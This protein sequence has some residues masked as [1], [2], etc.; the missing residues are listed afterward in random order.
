MRI[1]KKKLVLIGGVVAVLTLL[2]FA[3]FYLGKYIKS[4]NLVANKDSL[5]LA[6]QVTLKTT[7]ANDASSKSS[8]IKVRYKPTNSKTWVEPDTKLGIVSGN[9][10]IQSFELTN[11]KTAT[12][13]EY[14]T[15]TIDSK[16]GISTWTPSS[17]FATAREKGK[18]A[19]SGAV[20]LA[21]AA[22]LENPGDISFDGKADN[23]DFYI[24]EFG[25][26]TKSNDL[27]TS[28]L[29]NHIYSVGGEM[30]AIMTAYKYVPASNN[31]FN[32]EEKYSGRAIVA[33][34]DIKFFVNL[35]VPVV[36]YTEDGG[37][38]VT[39]GGKTTSANQS[40]VALVDQNQAVLGSVSTN[41]P[42][43]NTNPV[44]IDGPA[45]IGINV[46]VDYSLKAKNNLLAGK[47]S[48]NLGEGLKAAGCQIEIPNTVDCVGCVTNNKIK[49]RLKCTSAG[50]G[51]LLISW[52]TGGNNGRDSI[53]ECNK[54]FKVEVSSTEKCDNSVWVLE[55]GKCLFKKNQ[56]TTIIDQCK[57]GINKVTATQ[58]STNPLKYT[59]DIDTPA[60]STARSFKFDFDDGTKPKTTLKKSV[61]HT[62]AKPGLYQVIARSYKQDLPSGPACGQAT[63]VVNPATCKTGTFTANSYSGDTTKAP[64]QIAFANA[65]AKGVAKYVL[66]YGDNSRG[67]GKF[68]SIS[69][70]SYKN[71]GTYQP[72]L[73]GF[74][75]DG[76]SCGLVSL[77]KPIVLTGPTQDD[78][79]N[80]GK[81]TAEP[82]SGEATEKKPLKVNFAITPVVG[83]VGLK[84]VAEY[85][86]DWGD[87][88]TPVTQKVT[89][90]NKMNKITFQHSYLG[91]NQNSADGSYTAILQGFCRDDDKGAPTSCGSR[92]LNIKITNTTGIVPVTLCQFDG[93]ITARPKD[94]KSGQR[95]TI[96]AKNIK[97][98]D[99]AT[100]LPTSWQYNFGDMITQDISGKVNNK[101]V[102]H[103]YQ[104]DGLYSVV[105]TGFLE[106]PTGSVNCGS[107][108][109]TVQVGKTKTNTCSV[110]T[111]EV[112]PE[113]EKSVTVTMNKM[114]G[115]DKIN[116]EWGDKEANSYVVTGKSTISEKHLYNANGQYT[117]KVNGY[118]TGLTTLCGETSKDVT[119]GEAI[120]NYA[121]NSS[122]SGGI[123]LVTTTETGSN[124]LKTN[125][126]IKDKDGKLVVAPNVGYD[127]VVTQVG[128]ESEPETITYDGKQF[129]FC[130][131]DKQTK[132]KIKAVRKAT[133]T[134]PVATSNELVITVNPSS[135]SDK[136]DPSGLIAGSAPAAAS[137]ANGASLPTVTIGTQT[138][139]QYNLNVGT[140]VNGSIIPKNNGRI[141]KWCYN[142]NAKNC[143]TYGGLYEWNEMMKY[144]IVAGAQGICPSGFHV[145]TDSE[146]KTL[147]MFLGMTQEQADGYGQAGSGADLQPAKVDSIVARG[148]DQA[149]KLISGGSS[150]FNGLF[151]GY[152]GNNA[153]STTLGF[154]G[155]FWSSSQ[156]SA[157]TAW[158]RRLMKGEGKVLRLKD[159]KDLGFSV[160][161]LKD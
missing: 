120:I 86:L 93:S 77:D 56:C 108:A 155:E 23:A 54:T 98:G 52:S 61:V 85:R 13:Y 161:C 73:N 4:S 49:F 149:Q 59:F 123:S 51:D 41:P 105:L 11:L 65:E 152:M 75:A 22:N 57:C 116:I 74:D 104:Q 46:D 109:T 91:P 133:A 159:R 126:E 70:Y 18:S 130:G 84:T 94:A 35:P 118:K 154:S 156:I 147:E 66:I 124:P 71:P 55:D 137:Q 92:A 76:N 24:W 117:I 157:T 89:Q 102:T 134:E 42:Q 19:S 132:Y 144:S 68:D 88:Q 127:L 1:D 33:Q 110:G 2:V 107:I 121:D 79:A 34:K 3:G 12:T 63:V 27:A 29:T 50:S 128:Y 99:Q 87:N 140:I 25:D 136:C 72:A 114:K 37:I 115:A 62:F 69:N 16:G 78:S 158:A 106:T 129:K 9:N 139:M 10:L 43:C 146:Y 80:L 135:D 100:S 95:V 8:M 97:K 40:N 81:F 112:T 151:G 17:V 47:P 122:P 44:N 153:T 138:W 38:I 142:N 53:A 15:Q 111:I 26:G 30:T 150:G 60:E 21:N 32:K 82:L 14:Q 31:F 141:E 160:R 7:M 36:N 5:Y 148:T 20:A 58:D 101:K 83:R 64:V 39:P 125:F 6:N 131:P 96:S 119:V 48:I 28:A 67:E 45:K 143:A 145:P 113:K 103:T 90:D